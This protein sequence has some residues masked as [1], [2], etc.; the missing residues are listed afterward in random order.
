MAIR[1]LSFDFDGC[2]FNDTYNTTPYISEAKWPANL[3]LKAESDLIVTSNQELIDYIN[4]QNIEEQYTQVIT[5]I[6]SNRQSFN[7]DFKNMLSNFTGSCFSA[8]QQVSSALHAEF[9]PFLLTDVRHQFVS[10]TS[11][12][13]AMETLQKMRDLPVNQLDRNGHPDWLFD[14]SKISIIYAQMHRIAK[15]NPN[16]T[17]VFDFYE[18]RKDILD[19]ISRY[20]SA[21]P[22]LIPGN[23]T[24]NLNFYDGNDLETQHTLQGTGEIDLAYKATANQMGQIDLESNQRRKSG[25]DYISIQPELITPASLTAR[26]YSADTIAITERTEPMPI[27]DEAAATASLS[28]IFE[29]IETDAA[30]KIGSRSIDNPCARL[31]PHS[32]RF[33]NEFD[34]GSEARASAPV[35]YG[36]NISKFLERINIHIAREQQAPLNQMLKD[37]YSL[38]LL[39]NIDESDFDDEAGS[40][41]SR[42][43][44]HSS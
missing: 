29:P 15:K 17:I 42:N 33:F 32:P 30:T 25:V 35:N 5:L 24:L 11:Y 9:D 12:K 19:G 18:D 4:A 36:L 43:D 23:I 31:S 14:E 26:V 2:L 28:P 1:I 27:I 39:S 38:S 41:T 37:L 44:F 8:I 13:Q 20:F 7:I 22:E 3:I 6:G 21:Y 10:G 40:T 34:T 16:E